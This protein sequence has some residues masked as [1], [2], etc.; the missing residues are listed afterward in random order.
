VREETKN[1]RNVLARLGKQVTQLDQLVE[2]KVVALIPPPSDRRQLGLAM[3]VDVFELPRMHLDDP[4]E[5]EK[6]DFSDL[7]YGLRINEQGTGIAY[8]SVFPLTTVL[9]GN[10]VYGGRIYEITDE[11]FAAKVRAKLR[12]FRQSE[13]YAYLYCLD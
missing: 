7:S 9:D 3:H 11:V 4:E 12:E 8:E 6:K 13:A 5:T 2:G 1:V 10:A